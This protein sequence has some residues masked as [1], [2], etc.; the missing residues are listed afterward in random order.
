ML[1][2]GATVL[3]LLG[4]SAALSAFELSPAA[5]EGAMADAV[6]A[7]DVPGVVVAITDRRRRIFEAAAGVADIAAGNVMTTDAIFRIASMTKPI[8]SVA[9]M[10]LVED[11]RVDLDAAAAVYL[12]D[13]APQVLATYDDE[14]GEVSTRPPKSEVTV[15]QLLAHSSGHG[16]VF[17][18]SRLAG[19]AERHGVA[20]KALPLL[21]EPGTAFAYGESTAILGDLVEQVSG[22]ALDVFVR[23]RVTGPLG[24]KD[25]GWERPEADDGRLV[26]MHTRNDGEHVVMDASGLQSG[27]PQGGHGLYSTAADYL[28]LLRMFL[29]GGG[30]LLAPA[31]VTAMTADQLDGFAAVPQTTANPFVSKDFAFMSGRQGFGLGFLI[32]KEARPDR[33]AAGSYGWAGIAN[34]WFWV[35]PVNGIGVVVFMQT[36]PFVDDGALKT[37]DAVEAA[38]YSAGGD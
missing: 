1:R 20:P 35:D 13:Y 25:T 10:L 26:A 16:Y 38:I 8:T 12:D 19:I 33:R 4:S 21:H 24:M 2:S 6:E 18:D 34:T 22:Q 3:A 37:L 5:V 11:G 27:S 31:T 7:G 14:S 15:R 23:E 9:V 28:A 30:D 17:L 29:N 36:L 32:E